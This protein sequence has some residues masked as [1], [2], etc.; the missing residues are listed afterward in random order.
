MVLTT[1]NLNFDTRSVLANVACNSLEKI[2]TAANSTSK[3]LEAL[4]EK[5]FVVTAF[6]ATVTAFTVA[7][8][9]NQLITGES[10]ATNNT[11]SSDLALPFNPDSYQNG[12]AYMG[13]IRTTL[14]DAPIPS[15]ENC[16][17]NALNASVFDSI[18]NE[19]KDSFLDVCQ[20][21]NTSCL[22]GDSFSLTKSAPSLVKSLQSNL[23]EV[24]KQ[25]SAAQE[26]KKDKEPSATQE[27]KRLL[28][29]QIT[30]NE[31]ED[32]RCL[33]SELC[34]EIFDSCKYPLTEVRDFSNSKLERTRFI[35]PV[36][37]LMIAT[38]N[39]IICEPAKHLLATPVSDAAT[40]H[41]KILK[42]K[43]LPASGDFPELI[44]SK[45]KERLDAF[46]S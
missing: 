37:D 25:E 31:P 26:V 13:A 14:Q 10:N 16:T 43:D 46:C 23:S 12:Q 32:F 42:I 8:F 17:L 29:K 7:Y 40:V 35:T 3:H 15:P 45:T 34:M 2:R 28:C 5:Q 19:T 27:E 24:K 39:K 18:S 11:N 41:D 4:P 6:A 21:S 22:T 9:S 38:G 30:A 20:A 36:V 33:I 1:Q 44:F